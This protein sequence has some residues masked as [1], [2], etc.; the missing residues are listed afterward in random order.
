MWVSDAVL[1]RDRTYACA[2]VS[3][4][5]RSHA[6][7]YCSYA[8]VALHDWVCHARLTWLIERTFCETQDFDMGSLALRRVCVLIGL[9]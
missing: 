3:V 5:V 7:L 9:Q 4:I 6:V 2:N 8:L 1:L